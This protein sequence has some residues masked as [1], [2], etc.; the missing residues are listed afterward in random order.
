MEVLFDASVGL[1]SSGA[2]KLE[3][4]AE[5]SMRVSLRVGE[6]DG[7]W[8]SGIS[9]WGEGIIGKDGVRLSMSEKGLLEPSTDVSVFERASIRLASLVG[10][11]GLLGEAWTTGIPS[12]GSLFVENIDEEPV[13][14]TKED[15]DEFDSGIRPFLGV[16]SS[17]DAFG[18]GTSSGESSSVEM[19]DSLDCAFEVSEARRID[20]I[21]RFF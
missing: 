11:P 4:E 12:D 16:P 15:L 14:G 18:G 6:R 5:T 1:E 13:S 19:G 2:A 8:E 17:A 9:R 20:S 7:D 3:E 10:E 21:R